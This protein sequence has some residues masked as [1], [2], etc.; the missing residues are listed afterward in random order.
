VDGKRH[1]PAALPSGKAPVPI[2]EETWWASDW[3]GWYG[4]SY[5]P[6]PQPLFGPRTVQPVA[7]RY[8]DHNIQAVPPI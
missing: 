4:K 8:A 6:P 7:S 3:P 5:P 2:V 1:D